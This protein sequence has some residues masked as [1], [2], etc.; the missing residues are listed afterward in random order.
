VWIPLGVKDGNVTVVGWALSD[1]QVV[2]INTAEDGLYRPTRG[3]EQELGT[4]RYVIKYNHPEQK[5]RDSNGEASIKVPTPLLLFHR[6]AC[7]N[8]DKLLYMYAKQ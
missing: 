8:I 2:V 5:Q 4:C 3:E 6:Y 1:G 7:P